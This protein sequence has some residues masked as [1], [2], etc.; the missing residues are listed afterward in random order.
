MPSSGS[1]T[2]FIA[3]VTSSTLTV[4]VP[5]PPV[6]AGT[7]GRSPWSMGAGSVIGVLLGSDEGVLEGHPGQE[8]ALDARGELGGAGEGDGVLEDV[9]VGLHLSLAA[10]HLEEGLADRLG[11]GDGLADQELGHHGRRGGRDGAALVVVGD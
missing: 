10:H 6:A 2:S 1:T 3:S 8:C 11:L 5:T 7:S 9:L 4:E